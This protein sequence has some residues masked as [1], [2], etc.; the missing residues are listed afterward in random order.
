MKEISRSALLDI[1]LTLVRFCEVDS[2][3]PNG[4]IRRKTFLWS[5]FQKKGFEI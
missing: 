2:F 3:L 5:L 4:N 1:H